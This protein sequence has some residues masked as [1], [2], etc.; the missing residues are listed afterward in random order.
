MKKNLIR[1]LFK[2]RLTLLM[3][4][5]SIFF[6]INTKAQI[7]EKYLN[8]VSS[9][10]IKMD[11]TFNGRYPDY[12]IAGVYQYRDNVNWFSGFIAGELWNLYDI[13]NNEDL[14]TRA[15]KHADALLEYAGIDYTH[16]MGFIFM[17][18]VVQAYKET[19]LEK[20]KEA[21]I[22][23]ARML[24]KRY[25]TNGNFIKAWGALS[26]T[27]K[28]GWMIID[29]MLNLELLFWAW[30]ETGEVEFYDIAYKHAIT[31]M[32]ESVRKDFS[33]YHVIEFN[34]E[35]G[36]V[37]K[38]RTH[39]GWKDET[40]W[41]RGQA[42]GI[43]GF[44][45]AY[46]FTGDERFLNTSKKMADVFIKA[47]PKDYIPF[48]DLDLSGINVVRDAS[49]AAIA[50]SGMYILSEETNFK[51]DYEKYFNYANLIAKS[52]IDKYTFLNSNREKEE[53]LLIH[54]VYN[55]HKNWG[56]DESYP[57]GDFYF[58]EVL[59]KYIEKN[60][61]LTDSENEVRS[62]ILLNDNW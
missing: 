45:N 37:L 55:Y 2:Q 22:T 30:Q 41:A 49:A 23:A 51:N 44:A 40:T 60:R 61:K 48:W 43:Y 50:S 52:L 24:A 42:W 9:H 56:V 59:K 1:I 47:L 12:T 27:S 54:S 26:D 21:G 3:I 5:L 57:A 46:K 53:G 4:F 25:N 14:K 17:P 10:L 18:S 15:L 34:P 58:T 8:D 32:K 38:K 13:K 29:T 35:N 33:S 28:S 6:S 11:E 7:S 39:Q 31:C 20:Y 19:G 16:D 36:K 62:K